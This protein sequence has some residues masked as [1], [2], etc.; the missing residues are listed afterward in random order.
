VA[1]FTKVPSLH[2]A[3]NKGVMGQKYGGRV[4]VL[5]TTI[6]EESF[7]DINGNGRFDVCEVPAFVGG[8]GKPC[9]ADG[10][11]DMSGADITYSGNDISGH[12]YD[13]GEAYADYNEDGVFNQ[14]QG[15]EAGGELEELVDFN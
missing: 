15:F 11:F 12:P 7:P 8:T 5:A 9:L 14:E 6:G 2:L 13:I 3:D 1:N 10:R 4:T